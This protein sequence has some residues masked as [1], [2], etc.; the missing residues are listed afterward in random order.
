MPTY[1]HFGPVLQT[2]AVVLL[3]MLTLSACTTVKVVAPAGKGQ[4]RLD[5]ESNLCRSRVPY[6]ADPVTDYCVCMHNFGNTVL[7]SD[8]TSWE[9]TPR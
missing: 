2:T 7:F 1:L 6:Y 9:A 5:I 3:S 4:A 8:G